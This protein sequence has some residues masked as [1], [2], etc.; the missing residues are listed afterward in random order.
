MKVKN[1][2]KGLIKQY[3]LQ[4]INIITPTK[5]IY[6]GTV[7]GWTTTTVDMIL[8]KEKVERSE[9]K[10]RMIFNNRKAFIFIDEI[11]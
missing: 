6:S 10:N 3:E 7:F 2:L 11:N 9:V 5:V 8:Y 1:V 4:E